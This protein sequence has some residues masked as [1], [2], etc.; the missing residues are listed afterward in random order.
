[1]SDTC[2]CVS[3]S[4]WNGAKLSRKMP[5]SPVNKTGITPMNALIWIY[6]TKMRTRSRR[7]ERRTK[8][9]EKK[10]KISSAF[11]SS[12]NKKP[13]IETITQKKQLILM[14]W[15]D[16]MWASLVDMRSC[17]IQVPGFWIATHNWQARK[18]ERFRFQVDHYSTNGAKCSSTDKQC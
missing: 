10:C 11:V 6:R 18:G 14:G 4:P 8:F 2:L 16:I 3:A 7:A 15:E 1:M 13:R 5:T 17:P 9:I 12:V